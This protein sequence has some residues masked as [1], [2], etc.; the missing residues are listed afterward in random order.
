MLHFR[1][2]LLERT[3]L[4]QLVHRAGGLT[5]HVVAEVAGSLDDCSPLSV[6]EL[7]LVVAFPRPVVVLLEAVV[8]SVNIHDDEGA[9]DQVDV[10][11]LWLDHRRGLLK[12]ALGRRGLNE[13]LLQAWVLLLKSYRGLVRVL[14]RL[15]ELGVQ[16]LLGVSALD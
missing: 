12:L 7:H 1:T 5:D 16:W 10:L 6:S 11:L 4:L 14:E 2:S 13:L 3:L 15:S 8:G 9:V